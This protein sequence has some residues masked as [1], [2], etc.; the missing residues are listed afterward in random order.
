MRIQKSPIFFL[1]KTRYPLPNKWDFLALGLLFG[2]LGWLAWGGAHMTTPYQL[3]QPLPISLSP[4]HLPGYAGL[5][6]L[7]MVIALGLSLGFTLTVGTLAA[8]NAKAGQFIIPC[9]DVLQSVPVLGFLSLTVTGFIRLFPGS[10]LGPECAAIFA[11]FT[12]Q[13][14]NMTLSFYQSIRTVPQDLIEA[15]TLFQLSAWQR[16]WRVE[17]PYALPGLLWNMMLSMSGSWVFLVASESIAV[18]NYS[19]HLP[20]IGSYLGLAISRGSLEG[21]AWTVGAMFVIIMIYDQLFFRPL[22]AWSYKFSL[23]ESTAESVPRAWITILLQRTHILQHLHHLT[24]YGSAWFVRG[25]F[26]KLN[27]LPIPKVHF[28]IGTVFKG[29]IIKLLIGLL[30]LYGCYQLVKHGRPYLN[31]QISLQTFL[32]GGI[33]ALRVLMVVLLSLLIWVPIGVSIGLRPRLTAMIQPTVQFLAAF[34]AN[35]LFPLVAIALLKFKLSFECGVLPLMLL[36][37]QWYILFNVIAGVNAIPKELHQ[38]AQNLGIKQ[39]LWWKRL[40]LP[41]IFPYLIT[42]IMTAVGTAWNISVVAEVIQWGPKTFKAIGLGS[43][44][45]Q[46]SFEG[47]FT[48]VAIGIAAMSLWVLIMNYLVWQPLYRLAHS[49][50]RLN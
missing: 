4:T 26:L 46:A 3:G 10:R 47:N 25:S 40:I 27:Q 11:I 23:H 14:W 9:I 18:A 30:G 8:K 19:I 43:Y 38:I 36:G 21:V 44:I 28:S 29:F 50:Y 5:T 22:I 32:L 31:W 42:G 41:G 37:A 35:I 16:F 1:D 24:H 7:R 33:T 2:L 6:I 45:S 39:W 20:G 15:A 17:V 49:K 34:P 48:Q 12:A 13:V